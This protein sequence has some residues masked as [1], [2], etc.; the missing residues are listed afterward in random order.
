MS[1]K[2]QTRAQYFGV[3]AASLEKRSIAKIQKIRTKVEE[4]SALWFEIDPNIESAAGNVLTALDAFID[5]AK[6]SAQY[7]REQ[8]DD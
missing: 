7:L 6:E 5:V 4:V 2:R 8:M 3:S 1:K